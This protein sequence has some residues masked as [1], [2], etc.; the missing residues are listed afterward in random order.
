[1]RLS[2]YAFQVGGGFLADVWHAEQRGKAIA[3]YSLAPLLGPVLGPV[4]GSWFVLCAIPNVS[5]HTLLNKR[6][7]GL[8]SDQRGDGYFGPRASQML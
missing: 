4:C 5:V 6:Y 1:M 7:T 3:I 8:L 2:F